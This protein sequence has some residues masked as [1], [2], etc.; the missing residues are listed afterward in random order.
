MRKRCTRSVRNFV[1]AYCDVS[2]TDPSQSVDIGFVLKNRGR[3][4]VVVQ[5]EF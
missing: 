2:T 5:F 3:G 4:L 1:P